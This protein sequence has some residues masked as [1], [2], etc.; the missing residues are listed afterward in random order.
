MKVPFTAKRLRSW[1]ESVKVEKLG[2]LI[3]FDNAIRHF[4]M[5]GFRAGPTKARLA[6]FPRLEAAYIEAP[7]ETVVRG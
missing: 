2:W 3:Q 6:V 5:Y 7:K 1:S 4:W